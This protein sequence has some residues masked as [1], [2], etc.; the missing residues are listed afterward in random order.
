MSLPVNPLIF[1][2]GHLQLTKN[3]RCLG[4][5]WG[6]TPSPCLEELTFKGMSQ[7]VGKG[8]QVMGS[9][10]KFLTSSTC[11]QRQ[12]EDTAKTVRKKWLS[13]PKQ[14][15]RFHGID[16]NEKVS[17]FQDSFISTASFHSKRLTDILHALRRWGDK[18]ERDTE[19]SHH[20]CSHQ[21]W[22]N[23]PVS[24]VLS[25]VTFVIIAGPYSS[26]CHIIYHP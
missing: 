25:V 10:A 26:T 4:F 14:I 23:V 2:I 1:S 21:P 9:F 19:Q 18:G 22:A 7:M 8:A 3:T 6:R 5:Y 24:T 20:R 11:L 15:T 13:Q 12:C 16:D 17:F